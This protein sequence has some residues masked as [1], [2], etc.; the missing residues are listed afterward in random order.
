MS[1]RS[2]VAVILLLL[3]LVG[4]GA[5]EQNVVVKSTDNCT[6]QIVKGIGD[7]T[8][9]IGKTYLIVGTEIENNGYNAFSVSPSY[10]AILVDGNQYYN[11]YA[12]YGLDAALNLPHL[13]DTELGNGKSIS[14]YIA[15]EVPQGA[16][17]KYSL[18]YVGKSGW[19][20]N[21]RCS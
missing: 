9:S 19:N 11:S 7:Y 12:T 17:N 5:S 3:M 4:I 10:F 20:V 21:T 13:T 14:G 6:G 8:P 15:F 16:S 18:K 1:H 2:L